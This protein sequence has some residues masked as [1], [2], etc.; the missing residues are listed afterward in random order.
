LTQQAIGTPKSSSLAKG[1]QE[2][3]LHSTGFEPRTF[4]FGFFF[5]FCFWALRVSERILN[6]FERCKLIWQFYLAKKKAN[7]L[8]WYSFRKNKYITHNNTTS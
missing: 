8:V 1:W 5:F 7:N 2:F 3:E 6:E 4:F